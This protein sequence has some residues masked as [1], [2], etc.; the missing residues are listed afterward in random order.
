[1]ICICILALL[2]KHVYEKEN[3]LAERKNQ[4]C[5]FQMCV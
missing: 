2:S 1:M 5:D 3:K 4:N